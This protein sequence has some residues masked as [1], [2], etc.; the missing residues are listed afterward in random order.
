MGLGPARKHLDDEIKRLEAGKLD[1]EG[2]FTILIIGSIADFGVRNGNPIPGLSRVVNDTALFELAAFV[3]AKAEQHLRTQT[4][5]VRRELINLLYVR[6]KAVF[7]ELVPAAES[8]N[9]LIND[10]LK[11]YRG[12]FATGNLNAPYNELSH[13]LGLAGSG[14][15]PVMTETMAANFSSVNART[16]ASSA[17]GLSVRAEVEKWQSIC[18]DKRWTTILDQ[19]SENLSE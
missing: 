2:Q 6:S 4:K 11:L 1:I 8:F 7:A 5:E 15:V 3:I 16:Y 9:A 12:V 17:L 18:L 10:R 14:S 13:I 19:A